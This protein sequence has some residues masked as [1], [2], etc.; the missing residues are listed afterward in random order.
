MP[1]HVARARQAALTGD[2]AREVPNPTFTEFYQSDSVTGIKPTFGTI[3]QEA[4][5]NSAYARPLPARRDV[6]VSDVTET[7][8][9][10]VRRNHKE[11]ADVF[12]VHDAGSPSALGGGV[13]QNTTLLS[14][15]RR[16]W[17]GVYTDEDLAVY[18]H[19]AQ[20]CAQ[21]H[22]V[23]EGGFVAV[24]MQF[25]GIHPCFCQLIPTFTGVGLTY[26]GRLFTRG[27]ATRDND[28]AVQTFDIGVQ[29]LGNIGNLDASPVVPAVAR[30]Y[31]KHS[32]DAGFSDTELV[33]ANKA[34]PIRYGT[35]GT[36]GFAK[37]A[38]AGPDLYF[39]KGTAGGV[40]IALAV[41]NTW[42]VSSRGT[43]PVPVIPTGNTVWVPRKYETTVLLN[44]ANFRKPP[45][46]TEI[47]ISRGILNNSYA[48]TRDVTIHHPLGDG[49]LITGLLT[50]ERED[51][52]FVHYATNLVSGS[53]LITFVGDY[54]GATAFRQT[55]EL[56]LDTCEF[57]D[58]AH[59]LNRTPRIP[60]NAI[61][62]QFR[63]TDPAL[64]TGAKLRTISTIP[65]S[66]A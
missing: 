11:M 37:N 22:L 38:L 30:I 45:Q 35:G 42:T 28:A 44:G 19:T 61:P 49:Y 7:F 55:W 53:L 4:I 40:G 56:Q 14:T 29:T 6:W 3:E 23:G 65:D 21:I 43:Q 8:A 15:T 20:E 57:R 2:I 58:F 26:D 1:K 10:D 33:Y 47:T 52:E 62:F 64:L 13:F 46:R 36:H 39:T 60:V 59:D 54:I 5:A 25:F 9:F 31:T 63:V 16:Y 48:W 50:V 34:I 51:Q 17:T 41:A 18:T 12:G 27:A 24:D 66:L 32:T